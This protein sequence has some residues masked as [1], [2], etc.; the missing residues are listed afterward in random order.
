MNQTA[1]GLRWA[2]E[3]Y[4]ADPPVLAFDGVLTR[5]CDWRGAFM[6]AFCCV[7]LLLLRLYRLDHPRGRGRIEKTGFIPA[8][9]RAR[10]FWSL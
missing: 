10:D 2:P 3:Q 4:S 9:R 8:P 6:I 1:M 7:R 5:G